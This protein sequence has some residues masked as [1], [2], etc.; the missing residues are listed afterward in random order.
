[1]KTTGKGWADMFLS[2][3]DPKHLLQMKERKNE[4]RHGG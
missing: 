3:L 2:T 1:V 4:F